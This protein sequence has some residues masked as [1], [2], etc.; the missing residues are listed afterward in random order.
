M[1]TRTVHVPVTVLTL[2]NGTVNAAD[3]ELWNDLETAV[4]ATP[5]EHA[6]VIT[7]AGKAFSAGVDLKRLH[8]SPLAYSDDFVG[9]MC[10]SLTRLF[11]HPRPVVAAVNGHAIGAGALLAFACDVRVMSAGRMGLPEFAV[12]VPVPPAVLE[13]ARYVAGHRLPGLVASGD[14]LDPGQALAFGLVEKVVEPAELMDEALSWAR[15][16][17]AVPA[18]SY[19]MT[20]SLWKEPAMERIRAVERHLPDALA[21]WRSDAVREALA[22]RV[23]DL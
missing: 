16:L 14:L 6:I 9:A 12:G 15:R 23:A 4:D 1:I 8:A 7:G 17:A 21:A 20:K 3:V 19:A 2:S 18:E 13:I 11:A 22:K 10:A 5:D